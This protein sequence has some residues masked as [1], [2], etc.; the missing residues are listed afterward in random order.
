MKEIQILIGE[1]YTGGDGD[2]VKL[3]D[4]GCIALDTRLNDELIEEGMARELLR[5]VQVLRKKIGL[6]IEDRVIIRFR[7]DS[8]VLRSAIEDYKEFLCNELLC[9]EMREDRD[10]AG[11]RELD[12]SGEIATLDIIKAC[13]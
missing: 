8:R 3:F 2:I 9:V 10:L 13:V 4:G 5:Q 12:V 11:G 7:C 1:V 6:E